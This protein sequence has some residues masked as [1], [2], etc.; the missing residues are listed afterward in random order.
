MKIDNCY[1]GANPRMPGDVEK[2]ASNHFLVRPWSEDG[3][4]NYKF[5][6]NI[7]AIND[8]DSPE[9]LDLQ[10]DW[11]D[12]E[13]MGDRDYV[14]LGKGEQWEFCSA[15]IA[16]SI[17]T[18]QLTIPPGEWFIALHP[19]YDLE[20]FQKDRR[21]AVSMGME[22]RIVGVSQGGRDIVALSCGRSGNPVVLVVSRF[23]PYET[24]GSWCISEILR[25]LGEEI[26]NHGSMIDKFRFVIVPM[27]NPDGVA[28]GCCKRSQRGGYD[29]P[30]EGAVPGDMAGEA[31]AKLMSDAKPSAYLDIHGWMHRNHDGM[32]WSHDAEHDAFVE[33]LASDPVFNKKWRGGSWA[34][35]PFQPGDFMMRAFHDYGAVSFIVSP[36]WFGRDVS[37]MRHF[38]W[39]MLR[40][41][42][43]VVNC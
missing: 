37:D 3:D 31:L 23:H 42:C 17:S 40:A 2:L 6:L 36:S 35:K 11:A 38:G 33:I 18:V 39:A 1:E 13:Y 29:L 16:G 22:E 10:I 41:L 25:L 9:P 30:H 21:R 43:D 7:K 27:P 32:G 12:L 15:Q 34:K 4:G 5:N 28:S 20:S 26:Q 8:T 19:I 24:A 14:F